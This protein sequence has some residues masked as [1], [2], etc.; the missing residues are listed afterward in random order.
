MKGKMMFEFLK[1]LRMRLHLSGSV[2]VMVAWMACITV[3]GVWGNGPLATGALGI[4]GG[5]ALL[6]FMIALTLSDDKDKR[7][8]TEVC[9]NQP[10]DETKKDEPT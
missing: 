9:L 10:K 5:T 8:H 3:V 2:T 6:V 4:L 1:K 7:H